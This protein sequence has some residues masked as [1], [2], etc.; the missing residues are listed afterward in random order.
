[1]F[2]LQQATEYTPQKFFSESR[3]SLQILMKLLYKLSHNLEL[4]TI[5]HDLALARKTVSV[6]A[7]LV[8]DAIITYFDINKV[9]V[10]GVSDDGT[11]LIVEMDEI[12]FFI[13][14]YNRGLIRTGQWYVAGV[15]RGS[16]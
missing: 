6:W 16:K 12:L 3:L 8:R 1:M 7:S 15:E 4:M 2:Q 10:G 14:K 13:R 9:K 5:A 11:S